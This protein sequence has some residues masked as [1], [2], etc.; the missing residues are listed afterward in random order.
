MK[1][2]GHIEWSIRVACYGSESIYEV[3]IN[4]TNEQEAMEML[5][6]RK[7]INPIS[8]LIKRVVT[9]YTTEVVIV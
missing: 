7:L 5:A 9:T 8:C 6:K 2:G 3:R 1:I 4:P